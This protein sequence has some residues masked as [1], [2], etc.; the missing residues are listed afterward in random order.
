MRKPWKRMIYWAVAVPLIPIALVGIVVM[1]F[2]A[3]TQ[4]WS[5]K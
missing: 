2:M 1:R 5:E 4:D 3:F